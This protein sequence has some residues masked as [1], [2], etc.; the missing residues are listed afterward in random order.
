[1]PFFSIPSFKSLGLDGFNSGFFNAAW[2]IIVPFVC[3]AIQ[4]SFH[5]GVMPSYISATKL[6]VLPKVPNPQLATDFT[7]ISYCNTIYKCITKLLSQRI[8]II[9]PHLI[10]PSQGA[11]IKGRELLYNV[12]I[13]QDIARGYQRK[14]I[15]L[16]YMLKTD[17]QKHLTQSIEGLFRTC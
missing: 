16:R 11:F 10:D 9:L 5:T 7:P 15:S 17:L 3:S 2:G 6:I 8:E 13:C 12:L 1:M 4:E 14:G